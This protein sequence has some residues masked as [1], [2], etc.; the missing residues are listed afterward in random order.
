MQPPQ[1]I[2]LIKAGSFKLSNQ[3]NKLYSSLFISSLVIA[4]LI[5]SFSS[6][7]ASDVSIQKACYLI[8][9]QR[10]WG[11]LRLGAVESYLEAATACHKGDH[12]TVAEIPVRQA[13]YFIIEACDPAFAITTLHISDILVSITCVKSNY[14]ELRQGG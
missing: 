12:L 9:D 5:G 10:D 8:T 7:S 3:R 6:A 14:K 2:K 11:G 1:T 4:T 13:G